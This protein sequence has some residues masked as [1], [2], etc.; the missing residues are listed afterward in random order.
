MFLTILLLSACTTLKDAADSQGTGNAVV[1]QHPYN[2]VWDVTVG[3]VQ[4]SP[5]DLVT[6][7]KQEGRILA[8]KSLSLFSYGENVAI[9]VKSI[10][11]SKSSV[12]V[13]SKRALATNFTAKNWENY[14]QERIAR[15]LSE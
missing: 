1:Y 12:E 9:G 3:V 6:K 2:K 13:I 14:I 5:L 7:N 15:K 8:Q 11:A 4:S 10:G